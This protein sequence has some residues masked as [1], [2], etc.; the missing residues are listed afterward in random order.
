MRLVCV[1]VTGEV[2]LQGR[3]EIVSE[4]PSWIQLC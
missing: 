1:T 2:E 4:R 3:K